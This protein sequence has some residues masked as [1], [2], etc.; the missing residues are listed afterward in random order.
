MQDED[1]ANLRQILRELKEA[2]SDLVGASHLEHLA[3]S[4]LDRNVRRLDN[5]IEKVL[6]KD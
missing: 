3:L 1:V 6:E 4:K 2:T 5:V